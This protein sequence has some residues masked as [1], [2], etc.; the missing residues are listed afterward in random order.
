[1]KVLT[2]TALLLALTLAFQSLR[3]VIPIPIFLSTLLIGSLVNACLLV[4]LETVNAKA[5]FTI[6]VIAPIVAYFQQL[7]PLPILI[8]PVA[9]GN[10]IY[11]AIFSSCKKRDLWQKVSIAGLGKAIFM[12]SAFSW[13]LMLIAIPA[14]LAN[15][16][17][18]I[19]SWPQL[20]TGVVGGVLA[21]TIKK[22]LQRL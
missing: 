14:K 21:D 3:Y 9:L 17:L 8:L 13:L 18:F 7:L 10:M 1:M 2:R 22:R 16:L 19:M 20:V 5:A 12:Y 4:A 6:G 15:P 11:I